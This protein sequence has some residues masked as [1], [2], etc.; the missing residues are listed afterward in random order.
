MINHIF[1]CTS[2]VYLKW[3]LN[4]HVIEHLHHSSN[5][6]VNQL[7]EKSHLWVAFGNGGGK[8]Q[9]NPIAC[10]CGLYLRGRCALIGLGQ[11]WFT[12]VVLV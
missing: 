6:R 1:L 8:K 5:Q 12:P 3:V 7:M 10:S 9:H 2:Y 4:I 11:F